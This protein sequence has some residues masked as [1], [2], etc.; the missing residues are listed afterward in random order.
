MA[1]NSHVLRVHE[2]G[3]GVIR[4]VGTIEGKKVKKRNSSR[5]LGRIVVIV[6]DNADGNATVQS[7]QKS[8][9]NRE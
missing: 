8:T 5:R 7:I 9:E 3:G 4:Y 6:R 1:V 2:C